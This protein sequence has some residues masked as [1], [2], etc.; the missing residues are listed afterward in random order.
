MRVAIFDEISLQELLKLL[1]FPCM[2][3]IFGS[4]IFFLILRLFLV[5]AIGNLAIPD[6]GFNY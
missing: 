4:N 1:R 6:T 5:R 3:R 2:I